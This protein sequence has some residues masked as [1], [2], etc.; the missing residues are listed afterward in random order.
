MLKPDE[1]LK[2]LG[3]RA[4][5]RVADF[6]CGAGY[7][8]VPAARFVGSSGRVV[9]IDARTASVDEARRRAELAAVADR[10]DVVRADLTREKASGL[11]DQCFL[12][13]DSIMYT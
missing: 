4:G 13:S 6:G 7:Y 1:V 11:P 5:W 2:Q 9:G 8:L 10:V 3:I 12:S